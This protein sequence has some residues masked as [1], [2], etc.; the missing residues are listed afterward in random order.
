MI[1]KPLQTSFLLFTFLL[2]LCSCI[3]AA[4]VPFYP[5]SE[6]D[7]LQDASL[8]EQ[9]A[10][11]VQPATVVNGATCDT[12]PFDSGRT[13]ERTQ[14]FCPSVHPASGDENLGCHIDQWEDSGVPP[15]Y[16]EQKP[17]RRIDAGNTPTIQAQRIYEIYLCSELRTQC[18]VE[19]D[20]GCGASTFDEG[21][22]ATVSCPD[23]HMLRTRD[24]TPDG[25]SWEATCVPRDECG[26]DAEQAAADASATQTSSGSSGTQTQ[27]QQTGQGLDTSNFLLYGIIA[28]LLFFGIYLLRGRK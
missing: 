24:C 18:G 13:F 9:I 14:V 8:L 25:V 27:T 23:T 21:Q 7:R 6:E 3:M 22:S 4:D 19:S 16:G 2:L 1:R 20:A 12:H 17:S 26:F 5:L 28:V 10:A 15:Y 11:Q